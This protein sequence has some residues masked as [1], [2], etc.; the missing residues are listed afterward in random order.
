M[1]LRRVIEHVREQNWTAIAIDFLIVVGGVFVGF[2]MTAWGQERADRAEERELLQGLH[3]EFSEVAVALETQVAKHRR[4]EA[5]V[6]TTLEALT[7][8][9]LGGASF[10]MVADSILA[11]TYVPTTTQ[12][13]QGVL[14]GTLGTGRLGLIRDPELRAVLSEWEG[15]LADAT[16]DE[17]ASREFVMFHQD[18]VLWSRMDVSPFR[19]DI[20]LEYRGALPETD[21]ISA[22]AV[23]VE[24]ETIG[25]FTAR[26]QWQQH[27]VAEFSGPRATAHR[28]LALIHRSLE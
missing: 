12:L 7:R 22:S 28:I 4:V 9:R 21:A 24:L 19:N 15:V 3:T 26:L 10:A 16:E 17:V 1:I 8:A 23:P 20:R 5:A 18:P 27:V 14:G 2:Q 13:S 11:W 6:R 25:L